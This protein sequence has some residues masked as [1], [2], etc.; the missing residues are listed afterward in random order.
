MDKPNNQKSSG[1]LQAI[2]SPSIR[3]HTITMDFIMQLPLTKSKHDAILVESLQG[4][5][6]NFVK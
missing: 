2:Q 4:T 5:V 1:L 6:N 3:W